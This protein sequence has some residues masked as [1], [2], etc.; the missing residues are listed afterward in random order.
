[1]IPR[2][3]SVRL[4]EGLETTPTNRCLDPPRAISNSGHHL[5]PSSPSRTHT[6]Q[7]ARSGKIN[8]APGNRSLCLPTAARRSLAWLTVVSSTTVTALRAAARG[9]GVSEALSDTCVGPLSSVARFTSCRRARRGLPLPRRC[10]TA[11]RTVCLAG[12][13]TRART[14]CSAPTPWLLG[15][16]SRSL[17]AVFEMMRVWSRREIQPCYNARRRRAGIARS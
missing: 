10:P 7:L 3:G 14:G 17:A 5:A 11:R 16:C 8:V 4:A 12:S 2:V 9:S 1:M 13:P 6:Q 15:R